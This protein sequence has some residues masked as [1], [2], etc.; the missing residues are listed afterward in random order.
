M[1]A[2]SIHSRIDL[3]SVTITKWQSALYVIQFCEDPII[4]LC[5]EPRHL[6]LFY[7]PDNRIFGYIEICLSCGSGQVSEGLR[8]VDFCS[9]RIEYLMNLVNLI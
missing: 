8:E 5:Y 2:D 3:D 1:P 6:L 4:A 7:T 9:K